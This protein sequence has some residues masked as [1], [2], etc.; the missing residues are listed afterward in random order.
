MVSRM[1]LNRSCAKD[2]RNAERHARYPAWLSSY[3]HEVMRLQGGNDVDI[4]H[5]LSCKG[6]LIPLAPAAWLQTRA[7]RVGEEREEKG[8]EWAGSGQV[9]DAQ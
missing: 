4:E 6:L 7:G 8:G 5:A 2:V 1:E 3:A 9:R